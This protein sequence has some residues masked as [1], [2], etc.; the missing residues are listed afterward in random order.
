MRKAGFK[1]KKLIFGIIGVVGIVLI[2]YPFIPEILFF[3]RSRSNEELELPYESQLTSIIEDTGDTFIEMDAPIPE[4]NRLVIP[5]IGVDV[6]IVSGNTENAL[7]RGVWHRPNTGDPEQGG[8]FVVTGHRFRYLPPNNTTFYNLDK[9]SEGDVIIVYYNG[10]EYDYIVSESF[11]VLPDQ[12]EVESD[13]GYDVITLYTCT[14]IW[15]S[16][17]RLVVRALPISE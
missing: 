15:T 10:V 9:L 14:P 6:E 5:K 4:E 7:L 3:F 16:S 11:I 2:L 13:L 1:Y 12:L 17:K 8:N